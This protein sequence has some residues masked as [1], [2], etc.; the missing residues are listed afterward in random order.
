[1]RWLLAWARRS[2]A[3]A[4]YTGGLLRVLSFCAAGVISVSCAASVSFAAPPPLWTGVVPRVFDESD[5]DLVFER[6]HAAGSRFVRLDVIWSNVAPAALSTVKPH[7]FDAANP[8]DPGYDWGTLDNDVRL[9]VAHGLEPVVGFEAAP[10]WAQDNAPHPRSYN[11]YATGPWKPSPTEV[12]AFGHALA[13]RY[14]GSFEGLPRVR[15][16]RFMNEPNIVIYLAP[17][18]ENGQPF[19]PGWYRRMLA[20]FSAAVHGVHADN[21]VIAGSL[22]GFSQGQAVMGPLRFL[23]SLL[24]L[25]S[26]KTPRPTCPERATFDVLS[27]HP[28]T[29]GGPTHQAANPNDVS[30]GDLPEVRR[31]LDAAIRYHKIIS[32]QRPELWVTEFS[33]DTRPPDANPLATPLSLQSRWT[34]EALYRMWQNGVRVVIW[35]LLRDFPAGSNFQ[36]G[37]YFRSGLSMSS[38]VPKPTLTA[39]R[40]PFV[41]YRRR[42][43]TFVWGRTPGGKQARVIIEQR[44]A[45]G[46]RRLSTI[47]SGGDGIF[48]ALLGRK[49]GEPPPRAQPSV[50][51]T[52]ASSV[53]HDA[54][55]AY[56]RLGDSGGTVRNLMGGHPGTATAGVSFGARGALRNDKN[57]GVCLNGTDGRIDLGPI[58]S[59]ATVELWLKAKGHREAPFFSNR[60]RSH[61]YTVVESFLGLP[62]VFDSYSLLGEHPVA[63]NQWHQLVYTYSG[64]TG[65]VYVDG[66]QDGE[67]T[68]LRPTGTSD[69]SLGFDLPVGAYAKGC[70][71]E[72]ALYD[73]A[74]QPSRVMAHFLASGRQLP[75]D[76]YLGALRARL[77]GSR[78][79]SLP[80]SLKQPKDR[81]VLPFGGP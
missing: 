2:K 13:M 33:W 56:W 14:S 45:H 28:Y 69:A 67:I 73:H 29:T 40:F 47:G 54:P 50:L 26:G 61:Q 10:L 76:P 63:N 9:A 16:W 55:T 52:Y 42:G 78:D 35:F 8:G 66:R 49:I 30:L 34:A 1:M 41:A 75:P 44:R 7:G 79:A 60:T 24:C 51:T 25:S 3:D 5:A 36:S 71:D 65:R 58:S 32:S 27:V 62:H 12:A 17:E 74:L 53:L 43:G 23:R 38:D 11:G 57:T 4:A 59:P 46:W 18:F 19:A 21:T 22:G 77:I 37:L 20:A 70:V 39:F 68:Y 72:V 6:I 15:Y 64:I 48:T 31:V 81:F 80:F